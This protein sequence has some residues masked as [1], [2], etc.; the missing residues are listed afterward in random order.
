MRDKIFIALDVPTVKEAEQLIATLGDTGHAYKIGYQLALA[1][2][3]ELAK[4]LAASGKSIFLDMKLHDI[5][6]TITHAV[7]NVARMGVDFL[8][9]HAYPQTIKAAHIGAK[10]SPLKILAVTVLTSYDE[11][12]VR[13]LGFDMSVSALFA[14][15]AKQALTYGADG[16]ILSPQELALGREIMGQDK[17][18]VT[19]GIRPQGADVGDQK[20]VLTP[21]EAFAKGADYLVIG[22]PITAAL[23]PKDAMQQILASL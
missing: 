11:N 22:R 5:G 9:I 13:E 18:L 8:T 10:G 6:N 21:Q 16:L 15:R 23:D 19:P 2:G 17:L 4:D 20:R 12:D 1:G 14:L 3:L 7:E